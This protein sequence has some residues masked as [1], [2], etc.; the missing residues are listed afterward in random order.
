MHSKANSAGVYVFWSSRV[1][2]GLYRANKVRAISLVRT[3]EV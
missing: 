1:P 2:K 3:G